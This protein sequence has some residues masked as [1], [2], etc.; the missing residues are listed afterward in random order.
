MVVNDGGA[1][2]ER[3]PG[4]VELAVGVSTAR[5][6]GRRRSSSPLA[7]PAYQPN[8]ETVCWPG[9]YRAGE[10]GQL[11]GLWPVGSFFIF[12]AS[13]SFFSILCFAVL[14]LI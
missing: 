7:G 5:E 2:Q 4:D 11:D 3:R 14:I 12:S 10:L 6:R 1:G 13:Y 8:T 9:F